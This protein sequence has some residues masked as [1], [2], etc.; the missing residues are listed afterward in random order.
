MTD[1][2]INLKHLA[3]KEDIAES[4]AGLEYQQYRQKWHSNPKTF[5]VENFPL[6]LDI[7]ATSACNLKCPYCVQTLQPQ[8]KGYMSWELYQE[9]IN[10]AAD[11]GCYGVKYHTIGRGE[12]LLH[13]K[14]AEM[15][16]YAKKKGLIDVYVNTNAVLL[17]EARSKQLLDASLDRISFSVDGYNR[18][19]YEWRRVGAKF[20]NVMRNIAK[21]WILREEGQYPTKIRIQ[22]ILF[23]TLDLTKY[24]NVWSVLCDEVS[25][26]DFKDMSGRDLNVRCAEFSCPQLWQRMSVLWNGLILPCNH[27]DRYITQFGNFAD[28]SLREVWHSPYMNEMRDKHRNG[29][30]HLVPGCDG[31]QLRS[32]II[33][34]IKGEG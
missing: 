5:T 1:V 30:S 28:V 11:N 25:V 17:T 7:E 2:N 3:G 13:R 29:N 6:F 23:P 9:I 33:R 34:E 26:L 27:W 14:I 20:G 18:A 19:T 24:A 12:P 15:V 21:F 4:G 31:C 22:T 16:A 10:E 8:A 32:S